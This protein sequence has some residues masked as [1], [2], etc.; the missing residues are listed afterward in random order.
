[1]VSVS[2]IINKYS[3]CGDIVGIVIIFVIHYL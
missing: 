3:K 2:S 1:M